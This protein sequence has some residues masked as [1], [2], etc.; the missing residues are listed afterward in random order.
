MIKLK[1]FKREEV[2]LES[3]YQDGFGCM[4]GKEPI[5]LFSKHKYIGFMEEFLKEP[6]KELDDYR[7]YKDRL[8]TYNYDLERN[9]TPKEALN[10]TQKTKILVEGIK[11]EYKEEMKIEFNHHGYPRPAVSAFLT[12]NGKIAL[13]N[14]FHRCAI[15][16][17]LGNKKIPI[18]LFKLLL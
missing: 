5:E 9:Y 4:K 16:Y 11:K 3:L 2:E 18:M 1:F 6:N 12:K 8:E 15:M 7:Y 14:G 13:I 10:L 17:I